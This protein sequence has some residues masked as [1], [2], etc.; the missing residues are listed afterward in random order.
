MRFPRAVLRALTFSPY[1][2]NI[3]RYCL[4]LFM[5]S[6]NV[7][8]SHLA[9]QPETQEVRVRR[10]IANYSSA[11]TFFFSF[12]VIRRKLETG[13]T[14]TSSYCGLRRLLLSY[15]TMCVA[16]KLER[17]HETLVDGTINS[18]QGPEANRAS[19]QRKSAFE[20]GLLEDRRRKDRLD[21]G[22]TNQRDLLSIN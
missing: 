20:S 1:L 4:A 18:P 3:A 7:R 10:A 6:V 5:T 11:H 19:L 12:D 2:I 15:C 8:Y 16:A 17:K 22:S 9:L 13:C 21:S 14:A